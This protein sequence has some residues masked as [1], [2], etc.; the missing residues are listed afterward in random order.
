MMRTGAALLIMLTVTMLLAAKFAITITLK[1]EP[2]KTHE[3]KM[4]V[5]DQNDAIDNYY[6]GSLMKDLNFVLQ[7]A[8]Y[9]GEY[10]RQHPVIQSFWEVF[11]EFPID[12]KKKFL[13]MLEVEIHWSPQLRSRG[14]LSFLP[15]RE[16]ERPWEWGCDG[17]CH[18]SCYCVDW[19]VTR[20]VEGAKSR[21]RVDAREL[22]EDRRCIDPSASSPCI[23]KQ[24]KLFVRGL[25]C[26]GNNYPNSFQVCCR[27]RV[28]YVS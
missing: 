5:V 3:R 26:T 22:T 4:D 14:L 16:V 6:S 20:T 23:F 19:V 18:C 7:V 15:Q 28:L 27:C 11:F 10:Y 25:K 17:L 9:K 24:K 2:T 1:I 21:I 13:G 8:E 12:M